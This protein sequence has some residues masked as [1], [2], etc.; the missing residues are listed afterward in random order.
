MEIQRG[1]LAILNC[2]EEE[3]RNPSPGGIHKSGQLP[4]TPQRGSL[5]LLLAQKEKIDTWNGGSGAW[6]L[7]VEHRTLASPSGWADAIPSDKCGRPCLQ[8][9]MRAMER[10]P[11]TEVAQPRWAAPA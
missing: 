2:N 10:S 8:D 1:L 3:T 5:P 6:R 7:R 9:R 4:P 11:W